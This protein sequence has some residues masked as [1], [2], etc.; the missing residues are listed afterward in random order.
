M[1]IFVFSLISLIISFNDIDKY[2][3]A[4]WFVTGG[5]KMCQNRVFALCVLLIGLIIAVMISAGTG[6]AT[7][8]VNDDNAGDPSMVRF[9]NAPIRYYPERDGQRVGR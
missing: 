1:R 8:Y 5:S 4:D 9:G 7:I 2:P 6:G 3:Q